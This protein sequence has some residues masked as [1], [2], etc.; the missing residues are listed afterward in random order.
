MR[1]MSVSWQNR[2]LGV[3]SYSIVCATLCYMVTHNVGRDRG[4]DPGTLVVLQLR[5]KYCSIRAHHA[6]FTAH[7]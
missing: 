5:V 6:L 3:R 7:E 4:I 1:T 2:R